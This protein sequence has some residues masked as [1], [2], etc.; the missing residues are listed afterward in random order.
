MGM[1]LACPTAT[2]IYR[3]G[4]GVCTTIHTAWASALLLDFG[5]WAMREPLVAGQV[6]DKTPALFVYVS[7]P[8]RDMAEGGGHE[9]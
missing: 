6:T 5:G 2:L 3:V 7:N 8:F 4:I 9:A 1:Y